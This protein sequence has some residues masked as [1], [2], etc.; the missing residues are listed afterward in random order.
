MNQPVL[1]M[2]VFRPL[3]TYAVGIIAA[4]ALPGHVSP[5]ERVELAYRPIRRS[6]PV[7][8]VKLLELAPEGWRI[9]VKKVAEGFA[10]IIGEH[11]YCLN[12]GCVVEGKQG[13]DVMCLTMVARRI[14]ANEPLLHAQHK[15]KLETQA[16]KVGIDF[17]MFS[18]SE[19]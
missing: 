10:E 5:P 9:C 13:H 17:D 18:R 8:H 11:A 7:S 15:A 12:C 3:H 4:H 19:Q 16:Q 2:P 6:D 1:H 14:L